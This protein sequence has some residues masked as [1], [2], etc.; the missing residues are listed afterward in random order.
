[1]SI[2]K[3]LQFIIYFKVTPLIIGFQYINMDIEEANP[4]LLPG[5]PECKKWAQLSSYMAYTVVKIAAVALVIAFNP[6]A[7]G[8][9]IDMYLI[10]YGAVEL[11]ELLFLIALLIRKCLLGRSRIS[12][13]FIRSVQLSYEW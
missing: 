5:L 8:Q 3:T 13:Y 9:T 10:I 12:S 4:P 11:Y 2:L 1:M 6:T 7:C